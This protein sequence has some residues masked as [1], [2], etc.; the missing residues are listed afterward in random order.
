MDRARR[1]A[2][3]NLQAHQLVSAAI[4]I[5]KT[6]RVFAAPQ[7]K[8]SPHGE[9]T[10]HRRDLRRR[11][12]ETFVNGTKVNEAF[13]VSPREGR[14]QLQSELAEIFFRR[15]ELWPLGKGPKPAAGEAVNRADSTLKDFA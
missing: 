9:W 12:L 7:D 5:G 14:L 8:D 15:W 10:R 1:S 3:G 2:R 4:R 6:R 11:A 13:D